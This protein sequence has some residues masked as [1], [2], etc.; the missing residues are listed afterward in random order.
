MQDRQAGAAPCSFLA[1]TVPEHNQ[2]AC[3]VPDRLQG[4]PATGVDDAG[5]AGWPFRS[6]GS[7]RSYFSC[8]FGPYEVIFSFWNLFV[9]FLHFDTK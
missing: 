9:F 7:M 8:P 6:W 4:P 2:G 5:I 3:P 1:A